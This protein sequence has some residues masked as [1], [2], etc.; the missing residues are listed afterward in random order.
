MRRGFLKPRRKAAKRRSV[1]SG[2][3]LRV[4]DRTTDAHERGKNFLNEAE[5]ER[6]LEAA[7]RGRH[8][9]RDHVLMLMMYRHGFRV[10]E[11]IGLRRDQVNSAQARV[12]VAASQ[13]F[14]VG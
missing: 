14:S 4:G 12:W 10:S 8:G 2:P 9:V 11:A 5:V 13:K 1:K 6:L 3:E 7:K